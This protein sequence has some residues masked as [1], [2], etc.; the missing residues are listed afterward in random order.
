MS[1][2]P[3]SVRPMPFH[4]RYPDL[5]TGPLP[6][7]PYLDPAYFEKE[8]ENLFKKVWLH[9]G[10]VDEIPKKGDFFVKDLAACDASVIVV[11]ADGGQVKAFHNVCSHRLNKVIYEERGR[12]RKFFCKFHGWAYDLDGRLSGVPDRDSFG[13]LDESTLGLAEVACDVWEGFI[14]INMQPK[15]DM[16]LQEFI[17]PMFGG[18]EGYPFHKFTACYT[19]NTVVN[20]NWKVAL[21]AFQETYHVGFVHGRSIADS[22]SQTDDGYL[23]PLDGLCGEFHRRLSIAGNPASVYGNPGAVAGQDNTQSATGDGKRPI[24]ATALRLGQGGTALSFSKD[25][26]PSGLNWTR[27]PDWAFDINVVFPEFYLSLRPTYY[28]AYNFRPISHN[29]TLFE[30]RVYYPEMQTAGGRFYQEFMKV[31]LRD[32]L[33]EDM[34][35]LEHTQ[36]AAQTRAK[37]WMVIQDHEIMVRHNAVVVDRMVESA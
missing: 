35:T 8:K 10:R 11:R 33:L 37:Q 20:A 18:L 34:G 26:L 6:A 28:Q 24:A 22:L 25:E 15:P 30:A 7:S 1:T 16:T 19:W 31:A 29:Q 17:K 3:S 23:H 32:V 4:E 12:V 21:D 2:S 14:F 36:A 5:G 13:E 9:V 27:H